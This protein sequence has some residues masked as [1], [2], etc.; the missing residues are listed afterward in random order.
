MNGIAFCVATF[1]QRREF[2]GPP[3]QNGAVPFSI[4]KY[5]CGIP[6]S[7]CHGKL[8]AV[9]I[10]RPFNSIHSY[11]SFIIPTF[12]YSTTTSSHSRQLFIHRKAKQQPPIKAPF[13]IHVHGTP[14]FSC[15]SS[16]LLC[17]GV[18]F[19]SILSF[20]KLVSRG[21][22]SVCICIEEAE[23][24][25]I[26]YINQPAVVLGQQNIAWVRCSQ[27]GRGL[28]PLIPFAFSWVTSLDGGGCLDKCT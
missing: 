15:L 11:P 17:V 28:H 27:F 12:L 19:T 9:S 5:T 4:L 22:P 24:T 20:T 2:G 14:P 8:I 18:L 10:F 6:I 3:T 1:A 21:R 26:L 16:R 13:T 23:G 7:S 25:D